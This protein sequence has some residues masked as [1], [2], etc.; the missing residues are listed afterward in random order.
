MVISPLHTSSTILSTR[1]V[2]RL[3]SKACVNLPGHLTSSHKLCYLHN[4]RRSPD[5]GRRPA[6]CATRL[7]GNCKA[8][9]HPGA[10]LRRWR[11]HRH[12]RRGAPRRFECRRSYLIQDKRFVG[13][14]VL[15]TLLALIVDAP[16][17]EARLQGWMVG[18]LGVPRQAAAVARTPQPHCGQPHGM[19][20][21]NI[22]GNRR[23]GDHRTCRRQSHGRTRDRLGFLNAQ[24]LVLAK[25]SCLSTRN[26]YLV[27]LVVPKIRRIRPVVI[28][29][30]VSLQVFSSAQCDASW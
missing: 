9:M 25:L 26:S 16:C 22:L 8:W 1:G 19:A 28:M 30:K 20:S 17:L 6:G 21:A 5:S 18:R 15:G 27:I 12:R 29:L 7:L 23:R 3:Q 4:S 2:P 10:V 11:P 13:T 14:E 24:R